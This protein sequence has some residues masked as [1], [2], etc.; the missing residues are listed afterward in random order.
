METVERERLCQSR[1]GPAQQS[2]PQDPTQGKGL[3][4]NFLV[5]PAAL[6]TGADADYGF[7]LLLGSFSSSWLWGGE[8]SPSLRHHLFSLGLGSFCLT[9]PHAQFWISSQLWSDYRGRCTCAILPVHTGNAL[10][11][12]DGVG[13]GRATSGQVFFTCG[14]QP[15]LVGQFSRW[16]RRE[17]CIHLNANMYLGSQ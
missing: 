15:Y 16:R 7:I 5:L 13:Q 4:N 10:C 8:H 2:A 1:R 11:M 6:D 9:P 17:C 14:N 3:H 12:R